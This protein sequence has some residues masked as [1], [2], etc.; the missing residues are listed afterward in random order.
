MTKS[1]EQ[2]LVAAKLKIKARYTHKGGRQV[3]ELESE[4]SAR[5]SL[6]DTEDGMLLALRIALPAGS[7]LV[8][9]A[10]HTEP[11]LLALGRLTLAL[12][13]QG[14]AASFMTGSQGIE[15]LMLST[16][17]CHTD[18]SAHLTARFH[19]LHDVA[20]QVMPVLIGKDTSTLS[21]LLPGGQF[22]APQVVSKGAR[23]PFIVAT[24][25]SNMRGQMLERSAKL[26]GRKK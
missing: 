15:A 16:H 12:G 9:Q 19:R 1:I 6:V 23:K 4:G 20:A 5:A 10:L 8:G 21:A 26:A 2:L 11:T 7:P 13:S 17:L 18:N 24:F 3:V 25:D 22:G 14:M